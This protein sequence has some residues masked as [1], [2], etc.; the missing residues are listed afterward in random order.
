M[1]KINSTEWVSASVVGRAAFCPHYLEH[2]YE[3]RNIS[4]SAKIARAK[5]DVAHDEF[6]Q[7][8]M[9]K[10]C[11]VASHLYGV[12]DTRTQTLRDFRDMHMTN[13]LPGKTFI[14]LYY[15]FSPLLVSCVKA[16]PALGSCVRFVVDR[17]VE[18]IS[19]KDH[20]DGS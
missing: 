9:D 11:Y 14:Y 7:L 17:L 18:R 6:N 12:D 2:Q 10:R 8:A 16:L 13:N 5:G 20:S 19:T 3:G 15:Y 1:G 4:S